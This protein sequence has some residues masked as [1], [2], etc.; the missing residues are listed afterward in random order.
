[1]GTP[2]DIREYQ[3]I[4]SKNLD[5]YVSAFVEAFEVDEGEVVTLKYESI[6]AWDSVG[7]MVLMAA[8][9]EG[10]DIMLDMEDIIDFS[11]FDK[12][13]ELLKK[14]DVAI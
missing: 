7:H 4:M 14:Y 1:M 9:E 5:I 13:K 8:L 6:P 10:F 12:G 11:D 3:N 2:S